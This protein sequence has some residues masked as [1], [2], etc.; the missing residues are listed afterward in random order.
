MKPKKKDT[1]IPQSNVPS[2]NLVDEAVNEE[3]VSKH[4][5]D[6]L[7]SG[8]DTLKHEELIWNMLRIKSFYK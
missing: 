4:S 6:P 7:L 2:D 5:N 3:N 1:Q 8:E